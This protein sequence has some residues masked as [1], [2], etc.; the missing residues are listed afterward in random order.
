MSRL[1]PDVA[2]APGA[3]GLLETK[4]LF[5]VYGRGFGRAPILGLLGTYENIGAMAA[6]TSPWV[7]KITPVN[8]GRPVVPAI[9]L[10]YALA[11]PC[12]GAPKN[13]LQYTDTGLV[14][15]YIKPAADRGW[16]VI[17]D[18]QLGRSDP[19]TEVKRL[20]DRGYLKYDNVHVALDPEY[21]SVPGHET[22][23]IPVGTV[24][25]AQVNAVQEMLSQYVAAEHLKTQ[26]ILIVHQFGDAAVHDSVPVMIA[27][28][29]T[30]KNYPDVELVIDA[31]GL[32]TP[33]EKVRKYNVMTSSVTYPAVQFA[34]IKVFYPSQW[35]TTGHFD[36]P[37]LTLEQIF[38]GAPV[39]SWRMK[40]MPN[41]LI[42]A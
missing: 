19:A 4:T 15:N 35:A 11:I 38:G 9:D 12:L 20:I 23:G 24:T 25:A 18:V 10:I 5:A 32:G 16:A 7:S 17:L 26:K 27:E 21:H 31:D 22:P 41:V 39:G 1:W 34:G 6:D 2:S 3:V 37:P 8:G 36:K 13:C 40:T 28:K 29:T 42:I 14:E 30:L 33:A